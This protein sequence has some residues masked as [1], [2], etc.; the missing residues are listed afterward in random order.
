G[1]YLTDTLSDPFHYQ[2]PDGY[3]IPARGY[4]LVWADNEPNQNSTNRPDLHV[5]F[6]LNK[7]GEQIGLFAADGSAIDTVTFGPQTNDVSQGRCPD[8]A[9]NIVSQPTPTPAAANN[10][11][12]GGNTA[13]VLA[14]IGNKLVHQG[15]TLTFTNSATDAEAP[16]QI[17]TF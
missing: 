9:N 15:Q 3:S 7:A 1:Y 11:G 8:G 10:C 12:T 2:I 13:P 16:P 6:Q 14:P 17:L 4:L 5:N